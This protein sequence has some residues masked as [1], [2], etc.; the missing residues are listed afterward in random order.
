VTGRFSAPTA[1][2][3]SGSDGHI[4]PKRGLAQDLPIDM[5]RP[6]R[7][8]I[9]DNGQSAGYFNVLENTFDVTTTS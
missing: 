8:A 3:Q 2:G 1:L 9:A 5:L 6:L 4:P 7:L